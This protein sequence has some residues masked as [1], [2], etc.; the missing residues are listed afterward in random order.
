MYKLKKSREKALVQLGMVFAFIVSWNDIQ[1]WFDIII[2]IKKW[3]GCN[4][5]ML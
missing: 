2:R 4:K 1:K 3:E 5:C